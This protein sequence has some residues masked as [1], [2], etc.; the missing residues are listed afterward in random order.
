[1]QNKEELLQVSGIE[2]S[3]GS[4]TVMRNVGLHIHKGEIMALLGENGAGKS[5]LVKILTG[6]YQ[7]DA[8]KIVFDN[9]EF[10]VNFNKDFAEK[11]GI[12]IIYQEL[13][14]I[15][16]LTVAQNIYLGH[17]P[18]NKFGLINYKKMNAAAKAIIERYGFD[19]NPTDRMSDLSVAKKQLVEILKALNQNCK[20]LIMDEPTASLS[21]NEVIRLFKIVNELKNRGI[22]I[23]YISH[24]LKE[25]EKIAD[26]VTILR[27]G[28]V[29][30]E[31]SICNVSPD[32]MIDYMIGKKLA[33][34]NQIKQLKPKKTETVLELRHLTSDGKFEDISFQLK[35]GEVLGIGGLIGAG[36][37][38]V[39][40]AIFGADP[41]DSGEILLEGKH[42]TPS[43]R[44]A[45]RCGIGFIPEDRRQQGIIPENDI[46]RNIGITNFNLTKDVFGVSRSKEI[47]LAEKMIKT[48]DVH[49]ADHR[50]LLCNMSGGN[51]QKVV[52]GKWLA[53]EIKILIA[54]EPTAGVDIGAKSEIY[55]TI[56]KLCK[57]GVS[58]IIVSSDLQELVRISDRVIVMH[59]RRVFKEFAEGPIQE[60]DILLAA[61]GYEAKEETANA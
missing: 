56:E 6:V 28:V 11:N 59:K 32:Q 18:L 53:R 5:T 9:V 24:R 26:S 40:R 23:L 36:R 42:Y 31:G 3:F 44:N 50:Y 22:A 29:V 48:M 19:L 15:P 52:I 34:T 35:R 14:D 20:M 33:M 38:E 16:T 51:Q 54:D 46:S 4:N 58:V 41:F 13:S 45:L 17:E 21:E 49:P 25:I 8:G 27:D 43:L 7:R 10:P 30:L 2:K 39:V 47:K 12:S 57:Q 61:S 37:T 55:M 1:M 60:T